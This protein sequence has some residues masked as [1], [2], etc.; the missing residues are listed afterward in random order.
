MSNQPWL[1][2]IVIL[3]GFVVLLLTMHVARWAGRLHGLIA[4]NLLVKN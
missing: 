4:K 2:P 1:I 3:A